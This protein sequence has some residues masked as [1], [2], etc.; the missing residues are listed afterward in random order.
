MS[1]HLTFANVMSTI[2]VFGVL[3]GGYAI[4][5]GGG[6]SP[7]VRSG[8]VQA[9]DGTGGKFKT[10]VTVPGLGKV[11]GSCSNVD[12]DSKIA[13]KDTIGQQWVVVGREASSFTFRSSEGERHAYVLDNTDPTIRFYV[14]KTSGADEPQAT[15]T[16]A[17]NDLSDGCARYYAAESVSTR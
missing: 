2:A 14:Y 10:I 12:E 16:G 6:E 4:A 7:A 5:R 17:V 1:R 13:W 15:I 3:A 8:T 11:Q 9:E